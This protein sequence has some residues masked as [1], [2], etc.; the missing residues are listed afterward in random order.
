MEAKKLIRKSLQPARPLRRLSSQ[1]EVI[2]NSNFQ[3]DPSYNNGICLQNGDGRWCKMG[4]IS[5]LS[6]DGM[7]KQQDLITEA[8]RDRITYSRDFLMKFS[9]LSVCK[10]KPKFLPDHPVVLQKPRES[11]YRVIPHFPIENHYATE[12][13]GIARR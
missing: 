11:L 4:E 6:F 8:K 2:I 13:H 12:Q 5:M 7:P 9:S 3:E 1:C 10:K